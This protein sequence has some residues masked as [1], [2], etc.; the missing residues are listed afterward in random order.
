MQPLRRRSWSPARAS[1]RRPACAAPAARAPPARAACP[2]PPRSSSSS[3]GM[4]LHRK[5]DRRDASSRSLTRYGVFG[6]DAGGILLDA[7]QELRAHQHGRQRH[8]DPGLE[9]AVGARLSGRASSGPCEIGLGDG[10][11]VGASHQRATG[12]A[13][14][15]DLRPRPARRPARRR[16]RRRLGR[17]AAARSARVR[18]DD[19]DGVDR[20]LDPRMPVGIEVRL[21]GLAR[22]SRAAATASSGRRRR[23]RADPP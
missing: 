18:P 10:P 16:C 14:R 4:L 6:A 8:L 15:R 3:S 11:P 19:R 2:A 5:N 17:V 7:E 13:W 9:V 20:R 23:A 22:A 21:V 1:A 12:S